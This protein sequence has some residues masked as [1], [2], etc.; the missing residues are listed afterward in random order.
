MIK[1]LLADRWGLKFHH[2]QHEMAAFVLTVGKDG[3]KLRAGQVNG[4][5]HGIGMQPAATG[6]LLFV[7][8]AP[9]AA[10][11]SFLQSL[12]LDRPVV[13]HTGLTGRYDFTV[14]FMPDSSEFGGQAPFPEPAAG[15][16]RAPG[17]F[18]AMQEQLGLKVT[19]EKTQV[20]V[21]VVDRVGKPTAN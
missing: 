16:E 5:L 17:L 19:S 15:V 1:K 20:D 18:E 2:E 9:I 3:A 14:T 11:A 8:N 6:A 12:V 21:L 13:D 7:N 4:T 10:F